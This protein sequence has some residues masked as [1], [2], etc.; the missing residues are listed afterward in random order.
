MA[1]TVDISRV[2]LQHPGTFGAGSSAFI[3]TAPQGGPS[4]RSPPQRE[5]QSGPAEGARPYRSHKIRAC[6]LCRRRKVRCLVE[7]PGQPCALC[8][9][10]N[11][12]CHHGSVKD[13]SRSRGASGS[14]NANV[15]VQPD[16]SGQEG[17][18][19]RAE[20]QR[21]FDSVY[22]GSASRCSDASLSARITSFPTQQTCSIDVTSHSRHIV[23]PAAAEDVQILE[24]FMSPDHTH[25]TSQAK[26]GS[27][28]SDPT[29]PVL[30]TVVPRRREGFPTSESPGSKERAIIEQIMM[31][32]MGELIKW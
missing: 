22:T 3:H 5:Q 24:E 31:P 7:T 4:S 15:Q 18:V 28:S 12:H 13:I 16:V 11:A 23:G 30:Y 26:Y 14:T 32:M 21:R 2:N 29:R 20:T 10:H 27:Y 8:K 6:D 17:S 19:E 9:T 1:E 25:T